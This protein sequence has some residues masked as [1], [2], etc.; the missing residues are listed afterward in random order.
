MPPAEPAKSSFTLVLDESC[1]STAKVIAVGGLLALTRDL[2]GIVQQWHALKTEL[3]L[4][5]QDELKYTMD[6]NHPTRL[7]LDAAGWTQAQRVRAMLEWLAAQPVILLA[8][9]VYDWRDGDRAR[10]EELYVHALRWC[11]RR[12]AN[13]LPLDP[14]P[15]TEL[16]TVLVDM[17]NPAHSVTDEDATGLLRSLEPQLAT[18]AFALYQNCYLQ[19]ERFPGGNTAP[20]LADLG[21]RPE[22]HASHARHSD[23]LQ[24]ADL[25]VGCTR[26]LGVY[27]L[28]QPSTPAGGRRDWRE[29]NFLLIAGKFRSNWDGAILSYGLDF[30]PS[31]QTLR[32]RAEALLGGRQSA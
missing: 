3:G 10:V 25:V 19:P 16:H 21:F 26:E 20:S 14:P 27:Y 6:G 22:L 4:T 1:N 31:S 12:A 17:P 2:P 32:E 8:D 18:A 28:R 13:Q 23:L 24:I 11:L 30:F 5:A 29:Q 7:Q 15:S 9:V